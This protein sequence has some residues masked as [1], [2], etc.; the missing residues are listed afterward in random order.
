M[1]VIADTTPLSY[2]ILIDLTYILSELFGQVVIPQAVLNEL[3]ST[4]A[5]DQV[6]Q[7]F[8]HCPEWL[9]VRE[10]QQ[11]DLTLAHLDPGER[12]AIALA[13]E[14]Q[15]DLIL[16]D[17][18]RGRREALRRGFNITGTIG[19]LDRAG[20]RGLIDVPTAVARLRQTSFR[21]SP[22]LLNTLLTRHTS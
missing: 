4:Q 22:R 17:E 5:P 6:R 20:A 15:A 13:Q 16:L 3:Q 14:L 2:L 11:E 1:I 10:V 9:V 7:W 12:E 8:A 21:V 18:N 19:L